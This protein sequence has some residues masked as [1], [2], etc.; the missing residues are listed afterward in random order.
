[1]SEEIKVANLDL[2]KFNQAEQQLNAKK[3][4]LEL[5]TEVKN[6][7][8]AKATLIIL[9]DAKSV[10]KEIEAK[11]KELV[12][13]INEVKSRIQDRANE[14]KLI[15][16]NE[17]N[18]VKGLVVDFQEEQAELEYQARLAEE[19]RQRKIQEELEESKN[20]QEELGD[21]MTDEQKEEADN[22]IAELETKSVDKNIIKDTKVK[23]IRTTWEFEVLIDNEVPREYLVVDE[24][25]IRQA[26]RDGVRDINGVKIFQKKSLAV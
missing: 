17:I 12:E 15:L 14:L 4:E 26:I 21:F 13:P 1:M 11:R 16:P 5:I 25:L 10:E 9:K 20:T 19:K 2:R 8:D 18:R 7:D 24:K 23:G 3:S 6:E 22:K